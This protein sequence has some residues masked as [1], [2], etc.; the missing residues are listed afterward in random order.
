MATYGEIAEEVGRPGSGQAVSNVVRAVPD[1]PWWRIVPSSGRLYRT[2]APTQVPLL[3]Q[4]GHL[5]DDRRIVPRSGDGDCSIGKV[6]GSGKSR[7]P[8][9][10]G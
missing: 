8:G 6:R 3:E 5:I 4:E 7:R 10:M 1:L 2:H 9:G